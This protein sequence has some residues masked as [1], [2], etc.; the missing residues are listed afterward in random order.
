MN[1]GS[2]LRNAFNPKVF[3]RSH[4]SLIIM[5]MISTRTMGLPWRTIPSLVFDMCGRTVF[6]KTDLFFLVRAVS[7]QKPAPRCSCC[8]YCCTALPL[9]RNNVVCR[10]FSKRAKRSFNP[11]MDPIA[12]SCHSTSVWFLVS[13]LLPLHSY[14]AKSGRS[15]SARP[16]RYIAQEFARKSRNL[17]HWCM[18]E[19][20]YI[21]LKK[22]AQSRRSWTK[23][24]IMITS[25]YFVI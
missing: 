9:A 1:T 13:L 6:L 12:V 15:P 11:S 17:R 25:M 5:L 23:L 4:F 22:V 14:F 7:F 19:S 2:R 16:C 3:L 20:I 24:C 21:H 18:W 8:C 10:W